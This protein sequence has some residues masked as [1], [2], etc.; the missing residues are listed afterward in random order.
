MHRK[1]QAFFLRS[2]YPF[3]FIHIHTFS[4]YDCLFRSMLIFLLSLF[5]IEKINCLCL[6]LNY[7]YC[8]QNFK[9][10]HFI[11]ALILSPKALDPTAGGRHRFCRLHHWCF[12]AFTFPSSTSLAYSSKFNYE[13]SLYRHIQ[14][15]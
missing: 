7:L 9:R 8:K 11:I 6:S 12:L 15:G 3:V 5:D 10:A 2:C 14:Q 13:P 4:W 1:S